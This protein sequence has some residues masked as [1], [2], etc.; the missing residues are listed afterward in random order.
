MLRSSNITP[1]ALQYLKPPPEARIILAILLAILISEVSKF[2]LKATN[3]IRAP[4][5]VT[6]AV[7]WI[8]RLP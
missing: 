3:G 8:S 7:G 5:A 6:P 2:T 1:I 4:T